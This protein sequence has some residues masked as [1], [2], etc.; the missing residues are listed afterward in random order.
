MVYVLLRWWLET[1]A[2]GQ[3]CRRKANAWLEGWKFLLR[4][5]LQE[6]EKGWRVSSTTNEEWFYLSHLC[7][8]ISTKTPKQLGEHSGV[9]STSRSWHS[10]RPEHGGLHPPP[11]SPPTILHFGCSWVLFFII[12]REQQIECFPEFCKIFW[13]QSNLRRGLW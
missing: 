7:N 1:L 11:T 5:K 9:G 4:P 8:E 12:N 10:A 2:Q 13:Q 6:G 3:L